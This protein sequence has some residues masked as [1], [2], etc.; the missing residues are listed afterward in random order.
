MQDDTDKVDSTLANLCLLLCGAHGLCVG[1]LAL[2]SNEIVGSAGF[3]LV[4]YWPWLIWWPIYW[5]IHGSS[6]L[7]NRIFAITGTVAWL[8]VLPFMFFFG[9]LMLGAKT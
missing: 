9:A 5:F 1:L 6:P 7:S 2:I 3:H 8:A 4:I